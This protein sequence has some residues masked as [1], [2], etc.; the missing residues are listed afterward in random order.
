MYR[1]KQMHLHSLE[2]WGRHSA[3]FA[4]VEQ[5]VIFENAL[6]KTK[7]VHGLSQTK[8]FLAVFSIGH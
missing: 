2:F 3:F 5:P 8:I 4:R 6:K 1:G 7:S